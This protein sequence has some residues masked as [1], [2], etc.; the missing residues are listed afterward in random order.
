MS[1]GPAKAQARIAFQA[2][3]LAVEEIL[4]KL[5]SIKKERKKNYTIAIA[6]IISSIA[7]GIILNHFNI[8]NST[9]YAGVFGTVAAGTT[10]GL[11]RWNNVISVR[12][13]IMH[14]ANDEFYPKLLQADGTTD[15]EKNV[16]K[17]IFHDYLQFMDSDQEQLYIENIALYRLKHTNIDSYNLL[18]HQVPQ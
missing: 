14:I 9:I 1:T 18:M 7:V 5:P 13:S 15:P 10:I 17:T 4:S 3:I 16:I 2:E 6:T 8:S 12:R 11:I